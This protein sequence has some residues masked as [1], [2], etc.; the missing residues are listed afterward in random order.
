MLVSLVLRRAA[1]TVLHGHFPAWHSFSLLIIHFF[2]FSFLSPWLE[3]HATCSRVV[4]GRFRRMGHSPLLTRRNLFTTCFVE[5]G[6]I[7]EPCIVIHAFILFIPLFV[8]SFICSSIRCLQYCSTAGLGAIAVCLC[9]VGRYPCA[10]ACSWSAWSG[11]DGHD[12]VVF[13]FCG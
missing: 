8:R 13:C 7:P 9:S 11:C 10:T 4:V 2:L 3:V 1:F 6:Q 12:M 5:G